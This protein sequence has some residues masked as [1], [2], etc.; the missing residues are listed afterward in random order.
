MNFIQNILNKLKL[1]GHIKYVRFILEEGK[2]IMT[3]NELLHAISSMMDTK[4]EPI[5]KDVQVLGE[6]MQALEDKVQVLGERMQALEDKVQVLG[7]RMQA[8]EGKV[9]V[10]GERMQTLEDKVQVLDDRTLTMNDRLVAAELFQENVIMPRLDTIE[11]CY[12]DTYIRYRNHAEKMETAFDD[13]EVL[14]KV[15]TNLSD[16]RQKM[17]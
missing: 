9:Q 13:I 8:L 4:L 14:K 5:K 11:S 7:E 17:A 16:Q 3:D 1:T 12:T 15:V 6:R 2:D 10:L